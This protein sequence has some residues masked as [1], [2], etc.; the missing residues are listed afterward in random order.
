MDCKITSESFLSEERTNEPLIACR[1]RSLAEV[2]R[3]ANRRRFLPCVINNR[4]VPALPE[5]DRHSVVRQNSR[6]MINKTSDLDHV[7]SLWASRSL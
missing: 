5:E 3:C 6:A 4:C 1:Y 2:A 7:E